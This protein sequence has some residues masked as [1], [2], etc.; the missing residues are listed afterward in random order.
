MVRT[1]A[2]S[3]LLTGGTLALLYRDHAA[4]L[5]SPC[6]SVEEYCD[7]QRSLGTTFQCGVDRFSQMVNQRTRIDC[8]RTWLTLNGIES[9]TLQGWLNAAEDKPTSP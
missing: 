8:Y 4:A 7:K 3:L 9:P 2:L 5:V 1:I 6:Q